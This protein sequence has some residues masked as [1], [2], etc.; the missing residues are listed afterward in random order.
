LKRAIGKS[1]DVGRACAVAV[2]LITLAACDGDSIAAAPPST[3]SST[4]SVSKASAQTSTPASVALIPN[5]TQDTAIQLYLDQAFACVVVP[6]SHP[7]WTRHRCSKAEGDAFATVDLE[8][9]VPGVVNLKAST[10]GMPDTVVEGFLGDSASL[11]FDGAASAQAYQWVTDSV[12]KGGGSTVIAGVLLQLVYSP[13]VAWV[14]L[15][16]AS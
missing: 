7:A 4:S 14:T 15:K 8:G 12:P 5:L 10:I 9:P 2:V 13:P 16:S 3:P 1:L 6:A 11:P